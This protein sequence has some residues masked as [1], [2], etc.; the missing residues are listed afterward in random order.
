MMVVP[1][2]RSA[3]NVPIGFLLS[4]WNFKVLLL[5]VTVVIVVVVVAV[6]AT[7]LMIL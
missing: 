2:R 3:Y 4:F 6:M 1:Y 5:V 7:L